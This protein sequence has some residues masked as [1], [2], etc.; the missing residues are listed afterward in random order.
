MSTQPRTIIIV[1][2]GF[3][4]TVLAVNLM[5]LAMSQPL[6]IV[7]IEAAHVARGI[8][9]QRQLYPYLLN[10]TAARM[11]A[12][13]DDPHEFLAF[14]RG[15]QADLT[16]DAF[17]PREVYGAYLEALLQRAER[18]AA[19]GVTLQRT[20][21]LAIALERA[22]REREICVH[23]A[24]GR[25]LRADEVV[26]AT[27]NPAPA[28]LRGEQALRGSAR[29]VADPWARPLRFRAGE[30]VLLVGTGLTMADVALAAVAQQP[31]ALRLHALSRHGLLPAAQSAT[32]P[33]DTAPPDLAALL[34]E[35]HLE[36]HRLSRR[37]RALT[38]EFVARGGDWREIVASLR[39]RVPEVWARLP[40]RARSR[41][42]R[43][44]RPYWDAHRHRMPLPQWTQ[45]Q[46]LRASG[47][48][49]VEAGHLLD[50]APA[51]RRILASWRPRGAPGTRTLEVDR[52]VNCTGPDFDATRT[53]DR[54]LHSLLA[55]GHATPD[56]LRVGL[57]TTPE[58]ALIDAHGLP[59]H[60]LYYLGPRLRASYWETTAVA[61]L[62]GHA[63]KLARHL[64][65][66]Q[67]GRESYPQA[68]LVRSR[69]TLPV[70]LRLAAVT[71]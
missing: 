10:V 51:G 43:H 52:V 71:R 6:R 12:T 3:S 2:A 54:L 39:E 20:P 25:Q 68:D 37:L 55:Q 61:E 22:H 42:L 45:L 50:L 7:L 19:P 34:A 41:F 69:Q 29:Y 11:S 59:A 46:E 47:A 65:L 14:A 60:H 21:G 24:D 36:L 4:G 53:R 49:K 57:L 8:A 33:C 63:L 1:G 18:E 58:G 67:G 62:R 17:V 26:L 56:P 64:L 28:P 9:Y 23:L 48:L 27:G 35:P 32:R 70:R 44:L 40:L 16:G 15:W 38:R 13:P 30:S 5:R 66:Q 31:G